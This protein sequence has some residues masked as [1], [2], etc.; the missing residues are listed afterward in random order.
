MESNTLKGTKTCRICT[1]YK[2]M[3]AKNVLKTISTPKITQMAFLGQR[4]M[5]IHI[6]KVSVQLFFQLLKRLDCT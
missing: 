5:E 3:N 4:T 2:N 6:Y 1:V